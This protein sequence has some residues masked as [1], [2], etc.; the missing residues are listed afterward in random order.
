MNFL[1]YL[2]LALAIPFTV[3]IYLLR[4]K[5]YDS[6]I[7]VAVDATEYPRGATVG[8]SGSVLTSTGTPE[9]SE[10]VNYSIQ[11]PDGTV[12]GPFVAVTDAN[13]LYTASWTVPVGTPTGDYTLTATAKGATDVTTFILSKFIIL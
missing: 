5:V 6:V 13:G 7:S 8:I 2:I 4:K 12:Y 10:T 3:L 1:I 9:P 11:D